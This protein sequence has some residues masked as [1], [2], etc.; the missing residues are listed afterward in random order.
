MANKGKQ[1]R[2]TLED[3]LLYQEKFREFLKEL[4][5]ENRPLGLHEKDDF[6]NMMAKSLLS[7][8]AVDPTYAVFEGGWFIF[9][10]VQNL[11]I[12]LTDLTTNQV[13]LKTTRPE[14][15]EVTLPISEMWKMLYDKM[16]YLFPQATS[17]AI[18]LSAETIERPQQKAYEFSA[19]Q[20][21]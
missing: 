15:V 20:E 6:F 18:H 14:K 9:A 10:S 12:R 19:S 3:T 4:I 11:A 17:E 16:L 2:L 8:G 1:T 21:L 5:R 13:R 7:Q